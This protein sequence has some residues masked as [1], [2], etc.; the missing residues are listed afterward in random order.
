MFYAHWGLMHS[1]FLGGDALLFY[2]GESQNE[3]LAR[4]RFVAEQR[5]H[6]VLVG[7]PGV[8]KSLLLAR[9][10]NERLRLGRRAAQA[11]AAAGSPREILWRIAA[12]LSLAPRPEDDV[13]RLLRRLDDAAV[14]GEAPG[15]VLLLDDA[16]QAGPDVRSQL[17]RLIGGLGGGENPWLSFVL[18]ATPAN[19][20]R[21]GDELLGLVDLRIDL[22]PWSQ[23][24]M[25]GYVQHA[26]VEAGGDRPLFD[27]E[28]LSALYALT[29][30]VPRKVNRLADHAL[31][32]A[33][34]EGL[35][36]V[37]AAMIE[38]A[39]DALSWSAAAG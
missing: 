35:E 6:A 26:L 27:G 33:A 18:A 15:A 8:G 28:A 32:G 14:D 38:A 4:L 20:F 5:R 10:A 17:Y 23:H 12:G 30:G 24:D 36:M 37:D 31:L 19:C 29:D 21:L 22:E 39:H 11:S 25:S 1:P 7:Q 3:A 13:L 2:P 34:A 9:F 16:D